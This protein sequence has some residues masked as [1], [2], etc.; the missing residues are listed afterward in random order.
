[1]AQPEVS[2]P[3]VAIA[4]LHQNQQFLLQLR[5]NIPGIAAPGQWGFFGGHLEPG[6][7][8]SQA[9]HR[10][11]IEEIDYTLTLPAVKFGEY[12]DERVQRHIFASALTL[13]L[14]AL[15]LREGW[16]FGLVT[17]EDVVRGDRYSAI[18]GE[19]RPISALHR[20]I[21]LD[22]MESPYFG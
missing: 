12:P 10:E 14:A 18:A 1:M 11:L 22:F 2:K 17:P 13:P 3:E 15:T 6:E 7:T 5:D 9:L 8:P 16:D 4:I 19:V 21:L 20:K